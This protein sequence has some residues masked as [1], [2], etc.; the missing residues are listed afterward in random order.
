MGVKGK[1]TITMKMNVG[2]WEEDRE[3]SVLLNK[4]EPHQSLGETKT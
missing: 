4:C 1:E 3:E 2:P